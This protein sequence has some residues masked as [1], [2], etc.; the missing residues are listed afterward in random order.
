M[1]KPVW[2]CVA[3]FMLLLTPA[4][5]TDRGRAVTESDALRLF[6]EQSPQARRIPLQRLSAEAT[7]RREALPS[8]PELSYQVE[9]AGGVRDEFLTVEQELSIT[10]RRG[11]L[12]D[13]AQ[14][15]SSAATLAA[16][17]ELLVSAHHVREAFYEVLFREHTLELLRAG[18]RRMIRIVEIL[19][20]REREGESAGYD[21]LRA[22]QEQAEIAM[23]VSEAEVALAVA[24]SRFG[25][26]FDPELNLDS[27]ALEGELEPAGPVPDPDGAVERALSLRGDVDALQIRVRQLELEA[28]AAHRRKYPD[29]AVSAGWKRTE[30]LG[31]EDTGV[32]AAVTIPLPVFDR[33]QLDAARAHAQR[34]TTEL[35][36]EMLQREIRAGV[37]AAVTR[38]RLAREAARRHGRTVASRAG[39]MR[40]I[41]ELAYEE[42]EA[43]ILELI[44]AY[45]TSLATEMRA[46]SLRYEARRAEIERQ[47]A[48]GIEVKP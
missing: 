21:L 29:P 26:F 6:L 37:N 10:G 30:S 36:I 7:W 20:A 45:R 42:G 44:D 5:A 27:A 9:D 13:V 25:S 1:A 35:E 33:G 40:R 31:V 4:A 22:E 16:E 15:A 43:G 38:E 11:L 24:R 48:M 34:Q 8:N 3:T 41:A 28:R 32:F 39:E 14:A 12:R 17:R 46:L 19:A 23:A 2:A 18:Q 47:R